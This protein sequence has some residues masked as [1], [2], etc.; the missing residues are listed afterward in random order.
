M[1]NATKTEISEIIEIAEQMNPTDTAA[2]TTLLLGHSGDWWD[3]W[4]IVS[5]VLVALSA[6]VAAMFTTGSVMVHKREAISASNALEQ[7][8]QETAGKVADATTAGIAAGEKAGHAQTDIDAAKVE[9]AKQKTLTANAQL[10]T[11][12]LK[13]QLAW[14]TISAEQEAKFI[15]AISGSPPPGLK[16]SMMAVAGDAEGARYAEDITTLL[17]KVGLS[18]PPSGVGMFTGVLPEGV[19]IKIRDQKSLGGNAG[20]VLQQAFKAAGINVPG[21]LVP[22]MA[23]DSIEILVGIKPHPKDG[24]Q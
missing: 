20:L 2:S 11:E 24:K 1:T 13:Q 16:I 15:A 23:D 10:E 18:V 7:Y 5:V 21:L 12:H 19:I 14:R 6:A 17:R 8:K 9:L 22:S 4:M 3:F